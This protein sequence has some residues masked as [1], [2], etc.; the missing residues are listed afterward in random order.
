MILNEMT[1]IFIKTP[2]EI[3]ITGDARIPDGQPPAIIVTDADGATVVRIPTPDA[4]GGRPHLDAVAM[5]CA[6]DLCRQLNEL[7][8]T[9]R[10]AVHQGGLGG[11]VEIGVRAVRNGDRSIGEWS[12]AVALPNGEYVHVPIDP[13]SYQQDAP[14]AAEA[15]RRAKAQLQPLQPALS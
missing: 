13:L 4:P 5:A 1:Q 2:V 15:V 7:H 14:R 10:E 8:E 3:R 12:Y 6:Q 11:K 9:L